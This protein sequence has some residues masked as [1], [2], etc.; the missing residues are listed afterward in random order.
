LAPE[1]TRVTVGQPLQVPRRDGERRNVARE[2][3]DQG[4]QAVEVIDEIGLRSGGLQLLRQSSGLPGQI[5]L[6]REP[7]PAL[8][9]AE[10]AAGLQAARLNGNLRLQLFHERHHGV[11]RGGSEGIAFKHGGQCRQQQFFQLDVR[12][13]SAHPTLV[14]GHPLA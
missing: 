4:D 5:A 9:L 3:P 11:G 6:H 1:L 13:V 10:S 2:L 7:V 12:P 8:A 14:V